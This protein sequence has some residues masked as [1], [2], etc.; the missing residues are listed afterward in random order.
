M[1]KH[2]SFIDRSE[3]FRPL[4]YCENQIQVFEDAVHIGFDS[5]MSV[6]RVYINA[7]DPPWMLQHLK[8]LISK[9][10]RAFNRDG[11]DSVK[12]KFYRNPVNRARKTSKAKFCESTVEYL[13]SENPKT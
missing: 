3:L 4:A 6:K 5:L 7:T 1:A 9:R 11:V 2:L 12:F 10:Q 13:E 8:S